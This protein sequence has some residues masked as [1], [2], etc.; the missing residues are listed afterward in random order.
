[1]FYQG[2]F[3]AG[4]ARKQHR[5]SLQTYR[6]VLRFVNVHVARQNVKKL[7]GAKGFDYG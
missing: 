4:H 3:E 6:H 7:A 5:K 2:K 1:M